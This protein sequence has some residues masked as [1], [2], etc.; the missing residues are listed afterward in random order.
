MAAFGR[1]QPLTDVRYWPIVAFPHA[2]SRLL[3]K[4]QSDLA[5]LYTEFAHER[6][7]YQ[8]V[9]VHQVHPVI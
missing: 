2:T 3:A 8:G 9:L 4:E 6:A 1:K 5:D 7:I